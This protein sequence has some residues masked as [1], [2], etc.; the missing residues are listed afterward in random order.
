MS[1]NLQIVFIKILNRKKKERKDIF[2]DDEEYE[3]YEGF[4]PMRARRK[5]RC[6]TTETVRTSWTNIKYQIINNYHDQGSLYNGTH[7][8][9]ASLYSLVVTNFSSQ[10]H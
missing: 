1:D 3:E 10:V 8:Y 2:E 9:K 6:L 5:A 4:L 7:N